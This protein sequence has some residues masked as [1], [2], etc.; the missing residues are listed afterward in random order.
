M[1]KV[2]RQEMEG[3]ETKGERERKLDFRRMMEI[4]NEKKG[5]EKRKF[6]SQ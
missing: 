5:G 6:G 2:R 3:K 4:P 1:R